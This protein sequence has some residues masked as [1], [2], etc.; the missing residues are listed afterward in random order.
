MAC[1]FPV[2]GISKWL[3]SNDSGTL[4]PGV[5][6]P[7][8]A[9]GHTARRVTLPVTRRVTPDPGT[10]SI[11]PVGARYAPDLPS[12]R[13]LAA[14]TGQIG[15]FAAQTG[16]I[17]PSGGRKPVAED[18][19]CPV[20]ESSVPICPVCGWDAAGGTPVAILS[21]EP[22]SGQPGGLSVG[23]GSREANDS[24]Q[25]KPRPQA[26][27]KCGRAVAKAA[28]VRR[29]RTPKGEVEGSLALYTN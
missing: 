26:D 7:C 1:P 4:W 12:S 10:G 8:H 19:I 20:C 27:R 29:S 22:L 2:T 16:R 5:P 28:T 14:Q 21:T 25:M 23:E 24:E 9:P 6:T 15:P 11:C 17:L 18:R 13:P 3:Y